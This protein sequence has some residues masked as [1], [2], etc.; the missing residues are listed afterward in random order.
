MACIGQ[1]KTV[2]SQQ[3]RP[4]ALSPRRRR[5]VHSVAVQAERQRAESASNAG[6]S[7][8]PEQFSVRHARLLVHDSPWVDRHLSEVKRPPRH[9]HRERR[10]TISSSATLAFSH[11]PARRA[12]AKWPV[13]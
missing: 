2:P 11:R 3:G 7:T 6:G 9:S 4:P 5:T 12:P 13:P 8:P 1:P 10:R